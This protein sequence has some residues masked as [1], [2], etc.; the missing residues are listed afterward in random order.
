[1]AIGDNADIFSIYVSSISHLQFNKTTFFTVNKRS[2]K[3]NH[4]MQGPNCM[5]HIKISQVTSTWKQ[6]MFEAHQDLKDYGFFFEPL[7]LLIFN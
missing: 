4:D 1:M 5:S 7:L 6:N 2:E 3:K